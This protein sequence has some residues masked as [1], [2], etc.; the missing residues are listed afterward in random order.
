MWVEW[1]AQSTPNCLLWGL[2]LKGQQWKLR[3]NCEEKKRKLDKNFPTLFIFAEHL[4]IWVLP[5]AEIL[6]AAGHIKDL[7]ELNLVKVV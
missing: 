4:K 2:T 7:D 3:E 6:R 5:S 1:K